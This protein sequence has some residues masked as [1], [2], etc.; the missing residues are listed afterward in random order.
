MQNTNSKFI[1][2]RDSNPGY[3]TMFLVELEINWH[4]YRYTWPNNKM[5][6]VIGT[7]LRAKWQMC[8]PEKQWGPVSD[9]LHDVN[10]RFSATVILRNYF[11]A[12]AMNK[13]CGR[14]CTC[15]LL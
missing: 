8:E 10:Q 9:W 1:T 14:V 3:T 13:L 2:Q 15:S 6:F 5:P 7:Y 12:R 4:Y 11:N